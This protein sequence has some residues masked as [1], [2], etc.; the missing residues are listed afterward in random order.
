VPGPEHADYLIW[1]AI[2][3]IRIHCA[4]APKADIAC[5]PMRSV[6]YRASGKNSDLWR[7]IGSCRIGARIL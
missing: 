7:R 1:T 4:S 2:L 5:Q 6:N 3:V